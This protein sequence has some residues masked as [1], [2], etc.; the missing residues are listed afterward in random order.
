MLNKQVTKIRIKTWIP[1]HSLK[2]L[3]ILNKHLIL[4][5]K[6]YDYGIISRASQSHFQQ[7]QQ[8][9][10]Q[11]M[12]FVCFKDFLSFCVKI[13]LFF[14]YLKKKNTE[15]RKKTILLSDIRVTCICME[16][17]PPFYCFKK[18]PLGVGSHR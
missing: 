7:E 9:L 4:C 3:F 6:K 17:L 12:E 5:K 14:V 1:D 16:D 2:K 11:L 10:L 15:K 18:M 13:C 8:L